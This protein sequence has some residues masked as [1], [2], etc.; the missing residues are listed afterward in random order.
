[1]SNNFANDSAK[2]RVFFVNFKPQPGAEDRRA[3]GIGK[4]HDDVCQRLR[5]QFPKVQI[6]DCVDS[7]DFPVI[8]PLVVDAILAAGAFAYLNRMSGGMPM[9]RTDHK[10]DFENPPRKLEKV[11]M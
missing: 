10:D 9:K 1:M 11:F 6:L 5:R 8:G 4:N 3:I 2:D 7:D